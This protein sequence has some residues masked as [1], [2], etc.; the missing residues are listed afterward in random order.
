MFTQARANPVPY[1]VIKMPYEY[2]HANIAVTNGHG[3]ARVNG[4]YPFE[5]LG[6]QNISMSFPL[7]QDASDVSARVDGD[8][9]T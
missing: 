8:N 3:Y 4:T 6:Y 7:P 1:P 2:I 9:I 5:N